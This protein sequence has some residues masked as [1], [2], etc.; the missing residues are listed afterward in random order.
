MKKILVVD[1]ERSVREVLTRRLAQTG[2]AAHGAGSAEEALAW[3]DTETTDAIL[4][5]NVLPGMSGLK[6]LSVLALKT[7]APVILMTGHFDEDFRTDA[8]LLGAFS[9]LAKPLEDSELM[10]CLARAVSR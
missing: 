6:A 1:D 10:A 7:P 8:M 3:L 9:V 2:Y 4:L 5:D